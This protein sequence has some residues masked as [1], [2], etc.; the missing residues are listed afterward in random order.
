MGNAGWPGNILA[1]DDSLYSLRS[2]KTFKNYL[3]VVNVLSRTCRVHILHGTYIPAR[4]GEGGIPYVR[5]FVF[6]IEKVYLSCSRRFLAPWRNP[7][8]T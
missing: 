4:G 8:A 6:T 1:S 3:R 7:S 2:T 5:L